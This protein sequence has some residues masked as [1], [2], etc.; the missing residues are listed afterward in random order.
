[1]RTAMSQMVCAAALGVFALSSNAMGND[2]K[3]ADKTQ[4]K[5]AVASAEAEYKSAKSACDAKAGNDKDVCIKEAKANLVKAKE[6]A[7]ANR[8]SKDS[9]ASARKA[10]ACTETRHGPLPWWR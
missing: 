2:T 4:Y 1:M 9:M 5:A 10:P 8:K 3:A 6:D 7:K